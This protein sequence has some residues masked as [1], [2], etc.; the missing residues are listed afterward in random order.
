MCV[1][2]KGHVRKVAQQSLCVGGVLWEI[3]NRCKGSAVFKKRVGGGLWLN[4]RY[5]V[6]G[7]GF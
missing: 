1:I 3:G 5:V 7:G 2:G 4:E 6:G